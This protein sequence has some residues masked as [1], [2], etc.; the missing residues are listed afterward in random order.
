MNLLLG[1]GP[2][3]PLEELALKILGQVYDP[4][5]G[6][7]LVNLGLIYGL[8]VDPPKAWVRMTLTTPGCPLHESMPQ[9]VERALR[10]LPGVEEVRVELTFD[11]PW[12]PER[13]SPEARRALGWG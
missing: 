12:T 9:A 11:P 2:Q 3:N 8:E 6:L 10:A 4:E 7:D 5:L 13:L 1:E